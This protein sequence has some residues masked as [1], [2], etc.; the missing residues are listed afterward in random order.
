MNNVSSILTDCLSGVRVVAQLVLS[1]IELVN[2]IGFDAC[3]GQVE[4]HN[5]GPDHVVVFVSDSLFKVFCVSTGTLLFSLD[6][7]RITKSDETSLPPQRVHVVSATHVLIFC[8][9]WV[10]FDTSTLTY[11][12]LDYVRPFSGEENLRPLWMIGNTSLL[13]VEHMKP[14]PYAPWNQVGDCTVSQMNANFTVL[15]TVSCTSSMRRSWFAANEWLLVHSERHDVHKWRHHVYDF[16][17]KMERG[18]IMNDA[19][20]ALCMGR[21]YVAFLRDGTLKSL[22]CYRTRREARCRFIGGK[23]MASNDP[24]MLVLIP[25][26][27]NNTLYRVDVASNNHQFLGEFP[28]DQIVVASLSDDFVCAAIDANNVRIWNIARRF[29]WK[30]HEHESPVKALKFIHTVLWVWLV[31]G[32]VLLYQLQE[33]NMMTF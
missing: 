8:R 7:S 6:Q 17:G 24:W 29:A 15:H 19:D 21:D 33:N 5:A 10:D 13:L 26:Y 3:D 31:N 30:N 1:Y 2:Q 32:D 14:H 22:Y 12:P 9:R 11:N 4:L 18:S 16:A 25:E 27:Y 20:T 28:A 23:V